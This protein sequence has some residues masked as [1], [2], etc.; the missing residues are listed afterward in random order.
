MTDNDAIAFLNGFSTE[1]KAECNIL[2][3]N[4]IHTIE[5]GRISQSDKDDAQNV[6]A[7]LNAMTQGDIDTKITPSLND[8]NRLSSRPC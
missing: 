8:S 7:H 2:C 3:D 5:S 1:Q 4:K 6:S